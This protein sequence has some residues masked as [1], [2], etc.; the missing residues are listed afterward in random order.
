MHRRTLAL[1]T[2]ALATTAVM[3]TGCGTKDDAPGGNGGPPANQGGSAT[4]TTI[5]TATT[6]ANPCPSE[7]V[8][9]VQ[10]KAG[11]KTLTAQKAYADVTLD[12]S[13]SITIANYDL[14]QADAEGVF[15]P[16]LTGDQ[17]AVNVYI[18]ATGGQK[19]D[20]ATYR[21]SGTTTTGTNNPN[22]QLNNYTVWSSAGREISS[23]F[24]QITPS[25][26]ITSIDAIQVCGEITTP[27]VSGR[28]AAP[29]I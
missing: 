18:S 16:T 25:V 12:S 29:R 3:A 1:L 22:R 26:R 28:F 24:N 23:G 20:V 4:P 10:T 9:T 13:A 8:L 19:L 7:T 14:P 21:Q 11:E 5:A 27:E 6:I 15:Q 2:A 17:L